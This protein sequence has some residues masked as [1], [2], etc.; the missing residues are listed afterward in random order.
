MDIRELRLEEILPALHLVWDVYAKQ[1][2]PWESEVGVRAF[3]DYIRYERIMEGV[4]SCRLKI[5]GA[6]D[7]ENLIG[8]GAIDSKGMITLLAVKSEAQRRGVGKGLFEEMADHA[9]MQLG[10]DRI[11]VNSPMMSI[12]FFE[13]M[14]MEKTAEMQNNQGMVYQPMCM[15]VG[16]KMGSGKRVVWITIAVA[17]VLILITTLIIGQES[18]KKK[19]A[20]FVPDIPTI[21]LPF[22]E[23]PVELPQEEEENGFESMEEYVV[24][25]TSVTSSAEQYVNAPEDMQNTVIEFQ[26]SYPVFSGLESQ[27]EEEVNQKI[28]K[29]ALETVDRLYENPDEETIEKMLYI[30]Q[31]VLLSYVEYRITYLSDDF[32]SVVFNDEKVEG[33]LEKDHRT[34]L[35]AVNVNLKT[36]EVYKI[37]DMININKAFIKEWR[38]KMKTETKDEEF[39]DF[40]SNKEVEKIFKGK[41]K[42]QYSTVFFVKEDGMEVGVNFKIPRGET[43]Y[44]PYQW[45]TA[46]FSGDEINEY[47]QMY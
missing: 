14:G 9:Y 38:E 43:G 19:T 44:T 31:P 47:I 7:G 36:G 2:A 37:P 32:A 46:P 26:V 22:E 3:Q 27:V 45:V 18:K 41:K 17:L 28:K 11:Y 13:H 23:G 29:C 39:L 33:N 16:K 20:V 25:G 40:L 10:T 12:A 1:T 5:F 6:W 42:E 24:E 30:E 15:Q 8:A 34:E 35:R 21:E 4:G